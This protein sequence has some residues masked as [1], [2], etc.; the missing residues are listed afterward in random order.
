M[1]ITE[2]EGVAVVARDLGRSGAAGRCMHTPGR[3][4]EES[5]G[6]RG[7]TGGVG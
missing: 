2:R 1:A 4:V 5:S 7:L 3:L 6:Y